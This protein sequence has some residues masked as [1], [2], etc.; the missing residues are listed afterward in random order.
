MTETFC[1]NYIDWF[2]YKF[3]L[4]DCS[5]LAFVIVTGALR[6]QLTKT[7]QAATL[8]HVFRTIF[9]ADGHQLSKSHV[10]SDSE[11][12]EHNESTPTIPII[13]DPILISRCESA[14]E[15]FGNFRDAKYRSNRGNEACLESPALEKSEKTSPSTINPL[16]LHATIFQ[17]S[18]WSGLVL[19]FL[20]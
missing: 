20:R 9:D 2:Y 3:Q 16:D 4:I 7:D 17:S 11:E 5:I 18:R 10:E 13:L 8:T 6:Q 14:S 1:G 12:D 19:I 15:T